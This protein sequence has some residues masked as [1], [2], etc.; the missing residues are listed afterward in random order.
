[1]SLF[2]ENWESGKIR[3]FWKDQKIHFRS[4]AILKMH[5]PVKFHPYIS[6]FDKVSAFLIL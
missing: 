3:E 1:M 4:I 5:F 6:V 2:I